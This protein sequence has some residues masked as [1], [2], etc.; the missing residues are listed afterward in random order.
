MVNSALF[1]CSIVAS[2]RLHPK[3]YSPTSCSP[4]AHGVV[5]S[6]LSWQNCCTFD[7]S[8]VFLP[9]SASPCDLFSLEITLCLSKQTAFGLKRPL[10]SLSFPRH[11][12]VFSAL[13]LHLQVF[14][15]SVILAHPVFRSCLDFRSAV[16]IAL[17]L[18]LLSIL[19]RCSRV[20]PKSKQLF[21]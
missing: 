1:V 4:D 14:V 18:C 21:P 19:P 11:F 3:F 10:C 13:C 15:L 7:P 16:S 6:H 8:A 2:L 5:L 9:G 12:S 20:Q 17:H